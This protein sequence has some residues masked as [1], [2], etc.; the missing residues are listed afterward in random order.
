M[1]KSV[2]ATGND[3]ALDHSLGISI[4][5]RDG[6][7]N[8]GKLVH[9]FDGPEDGSSSPQ[10]GRVYIPTC[11]VLETWGLGHMKAWAHLTVRWRS[12]MTRHIWIGPS[13]CESFV[14]HSME[15]RLHL[16]CLNCG[17]GYNFVLGLHCGIIRAPNAVMVIAFLGC[18]YQAVVHY[19]MQSWGRTCWLALSA[20][21]AQRLRLFMQLSGTLIVWI[22][23]IC[24]WIKSFN[25]ALST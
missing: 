1:L 19:M 14:K 9:A 15:T 12:D 22:R 18:W 10:Q 11:M 8:M 4:T 5:L 16:Q 6:A 25:T 23:E 2:S 17:V 7:L 3:T 20:A 13:Y 21:R 24:P